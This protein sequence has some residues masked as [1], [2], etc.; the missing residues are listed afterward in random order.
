MNEP[1]KEGDIVWVKTR[2]YYV[3]NIG[4][5]QCLGLDSVTVWNGFQRNPN[6]IKR[7]DYV[8]RLEAMLGKA[9]EMAACG[10]TD[11]EWL[12]WLEELDNESK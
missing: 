4:G 9:K 6:D 7:G 1:F 5:E 2:I 3:D 8:E 10:V 11:G 12:Q